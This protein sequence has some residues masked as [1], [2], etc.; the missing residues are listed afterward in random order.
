MNYITTI[1]KSNAKKLE[2]AQEYTTKFPNDF[3]MI[4]VDEYFTMIR[5]TKYI[6]QSFLNK[7]KRLNNVLI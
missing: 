1:H 4:K 7:V 5:A 2:V 6:G 3:V